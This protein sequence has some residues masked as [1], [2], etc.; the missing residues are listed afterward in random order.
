MLAKPHL[1]LLS[2]AATICGAELIR[3]FIFGDNIAVDIPLHDTFLIISYSHIALFLA[4]ILLGMAFLY[5]L[6]AQSHFHYNKWLTLGHFA[7]V[8][9]FIITFYK[10]TLISSTIPRRYYSFSDYDPI[11]NIYEN[12]DY[13]NR[14]LTLL[15]LLSVFFFVLNL[16]V[17]Y[18]KRKIN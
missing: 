1:L 6:G 15:G 10:L 11:A 2:L 17:G 14:L 5:K 4:L 7:S 13:T 9:F 16:I 18:L 3:T 12:I 8:C